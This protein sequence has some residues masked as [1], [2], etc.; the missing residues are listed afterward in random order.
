MVESMTLEE[1]AKLRLEARAEHF[2][3]RE[4]RAVHTKEMTRKMAAGES[5]DADF[6]ARGAELDA[7]EKAAQLKF[8]DLD[9]RHMAAFKAAT[10]P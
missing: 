3:T 2:A 8:K 4:A 10:A 5:I 1:L 7:A 9:K 6:A